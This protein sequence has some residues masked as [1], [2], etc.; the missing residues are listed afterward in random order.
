V[1]HRD[2]SLA[3]DF[4]LEQLRSMLMMRL[5]GELLRTGLESTTDAEFIREAIASV[6]AYMQIPPPPSPEYLR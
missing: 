2:A 6:C 1:G 4:A 3:I 5:D